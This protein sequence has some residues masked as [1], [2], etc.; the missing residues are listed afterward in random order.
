MSEV[1]SYEDLKAISGYETPQEVS[2][3]A[4]RCSVKIF[5]GKHNRP[6]TTKMALNVALGVQENTN[7]EANDVIDVD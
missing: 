1:I 2:A 7:E 3:W 6:A 4:G 5:P